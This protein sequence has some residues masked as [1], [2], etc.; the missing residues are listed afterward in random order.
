MEMV[1]EMT[2][3]AHR[4]TRRHLVRRTR[5]GLNGGVPPS[6]KRSFVLLAVLIGFLMSSPV[7]LVSWSIGPEA[8]WTFLTVG[9][10]VLVLPW[11]A[12]VAGAVARPH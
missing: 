5:T 8:Y 6:V 9:A 4:A 11:A 7:L 12:F 2:A 1:Q 3:V 10:L